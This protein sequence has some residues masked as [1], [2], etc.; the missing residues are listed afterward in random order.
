MHGDYGVDDVVLSMPCIVGND[1][2]ETQ[3]PIVLSEEEKLKLQESAKVLKAT[4]D[5]LD[6]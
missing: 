1:G 3:V 2:I 4:V 6:I 5:S